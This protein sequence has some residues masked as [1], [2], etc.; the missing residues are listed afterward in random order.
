MPDLGKVIPTEKLPDFSVF[1]KYLSLGGSYS[2]MDDDGFTMTGFTLRRSRARDRG[3]GCAMIKRV[4][5]RLAAASPAGRARVAGAFG[6]EQ[7]ARRTARRSRHPADA[8]D[9]ARVDARSTHPR[10]IHLRGV[11]TH[12]LKGIDLDLPLNRLIVVTGVSGSGKSSL[13]FDTLY[14]EGQRRYVETFSPTPASSSRSSTSPTPIGSTASRRPSR[15]AQP[16]GRHS[17][18]STVGTI[19][20][21]HDALGLLFARAGEVICRNCGQRVEPAS[22]ATVS[23]AIE[24]LPAGTRYE[25]AFPLESAPRD[26][27]G[28]PACGRCAPRA[29][30]GFASNG[31]TVA[32]R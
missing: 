30:R 25:I 15:S 13:A 28:G 19:T 2:V 11:R 22:P 17:G 10:S 18:R 8:G 5:Q 12:N 16:H 29:S 23:R 9:H 7:P 1:A 21:I 31:Q 6:I 27:S 4:R 26:R 24:A 32:A 14:A 3:A 20:E